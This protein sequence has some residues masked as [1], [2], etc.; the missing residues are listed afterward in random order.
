MLRLIKQ[1]FIALLRFSG[2]LTTKF[3]SLNY[4]PYVT[5]ATLIG[6]NLDELNYYP[7][8]VSLDEWY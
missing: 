5:R 3:V 6:L 7:F 8:I 2:S 1:V 4:E